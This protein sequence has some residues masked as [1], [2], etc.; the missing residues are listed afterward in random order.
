[1]VLKFCVRVLTNKQYKI[2]GRKQIGDD[3]QVFFVDMSGRKVWLMLMG[4]GE[5]CC[6]FADTEMKTPIGW[7]FLLESTNLI[8]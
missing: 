8:H 1:M 2:R 5:E 3:F 4:F 7:K 6:R